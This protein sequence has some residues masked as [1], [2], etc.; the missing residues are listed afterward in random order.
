MVSTS[1]H[2]LIMYVLLHSFFLPFFQFL[3]HKAKVEFATCGGKSDVC[4]Q[5]ISIERGEDI[6]F[7]TALKF[8]GGGFCNL[9]Q[10]IGS[11][12]LRKDGNQ[13]VRCQ[14]SCMTGPD[15]MYN[16][17]DNVTK[18]NATDEDAGTY[19]LG[20]YVKGPHSRILYKTYIV[21]VKGNCG[22]FLCFT[23][24]GEKIQ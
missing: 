7:D 6:V 10:S 16:K 18:I 20:V 5:N 23:Q 8:S 15:F 12:E 24:N 4:A 9:S 1:C 2:Q 19:Y 21:V 11:L 22:F 13:L 3:A 17:F 14:T